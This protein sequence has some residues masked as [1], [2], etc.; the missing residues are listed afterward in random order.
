[1]ARK[2]KSQIGEELVFALKRP[3]ENV[4]A[5][6]VGLVLSFIP[7]INFFFL[8]YV[9][10]N[11]R[12]VLKRKDMPAWEDW[13]KK[14]VDGLK[15]F[16]AGIVYM[17]IPL[18]LIAYGTY[19]TIKPILYGGTITS[20]LSAGTTTLIGLLLALV[21]GYFFAAAI[22]RMAEKD[23]LGAAFE[24]GEIAKKA[25]T[26]NYFLYWLIA[27]IIGGIIT[28]ILKFIPV[29]GGIIAAYYV[30]MFSTTFIALGYQKA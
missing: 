15:Y 1:M 7:I 21:F 8:G 19:K 28:A 2:R 9:L 3:F 20:I 29:I 25:L 11:I 24:L 12:A 23:R 30:T 10:E 16:A 6:I 22:I 27:V 26:V 17:I 4:G 14:F 13:G 18:I 5:G